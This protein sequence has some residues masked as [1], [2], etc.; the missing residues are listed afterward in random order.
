[1]LRDFQADLENQIFAA[2]QQP[3]VFN[4]MPVLATGGGKTVLVSSIIQKFGVP[5]AAIAH[6]QELVSQ[7]ALTLNRDR[8]PHGIIAPKKVI[9]AI[10]AIEHD[11]FGYS[12]YNHRADV[13]VAGIHT[14]LNHDIN[15][16]WLQ[17]VGLAVFD[18]GHHVIK[19]SI[20]HK[21]MQMM[22]NAR[23]L[24]PTAHAIR[25][26]G[27]GLGR[28]A[29][30]IVD[31]LCV[32][33][34]ARELINRGYLTDYEILCPESDLDFS[35]L[36]IGPT[37]EYSMPKLRA[38]THKSKKLVGSV[39]G[40]YM[41]HAAGKLGL[42]FAVDIIGAKDICTGF[43]RAGIPA[44]IITAHTPIAQRARIMKQFRARQLLQ[45]V[46]VDTLGEGTDVPAVEVVSMARRTASW[47][48]FSQQLG[49]LLRILVTD[50]QNKEWGGYTDGQRIQ[51]IASSVKPKGLLIDHV[52]NTIF[53]SEDH[54][55]PCSKQEYDLKRRPRALRGKSDAIPLRPCPA[56]T[57]PY[58]RYRVA[59]PYCRFEPLP[60]GRSTPEEVEGD[61]FLLDL[62]ALE[63]MRRDV[64]RS[65]GAPTMPIGASGEIIGAIRKRHYERMQAQSA[66]R[67][68]MEFWGGWRK[69]FGEDHR[70]AQKRF[71]LTFQIDYL[72]AQCLNATDADALRERIEMHLA[73]N[74]VMR[75]A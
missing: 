36:E 13:R 75:A 70:E 37:G 26:D 47:Q 55:L 54:G 72:S 43:R 23:G 29:D 34:Y 41:K 24:L 9:Q 56:C 48:L 15:D 44:E 63:A 8:V 45:L 10:I 21:G 3:N 51:L 1:M 12:T 53:H 65:D 18:E 64:K 30:G 25:A 7:M 5:T 27:K 71:Y 35:H 61:L 20:W 2:W 32:G 58:E 67:E 50:Q 49:R 46:S 74:S 14:L 6:R 4:V 57:K 19:G 66:M 33:S 73:K 39:V 38:E 62:K 40:E 68:A 69:T 42:T 22:P 59:C 16:R 31:A 52:G 60:A 17:A 28:E 11:T